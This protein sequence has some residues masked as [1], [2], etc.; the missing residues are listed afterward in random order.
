MPADTLLPGDMKSPIALPKPNAEL[1]PVITVS[2]ATAA[3]FLL[4]RGGSEARTSPPRKSSCVSSG[5]AFG[6]NNEPKKSDI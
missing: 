1:T 5:S 3:K 2:L 4:L 6:F